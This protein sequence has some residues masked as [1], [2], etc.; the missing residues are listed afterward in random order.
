MMSNADKEIDMTEKTLSD[1][2]PGARL[3][4]RRDSPVW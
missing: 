2:P 4:Q 1:I 3:V